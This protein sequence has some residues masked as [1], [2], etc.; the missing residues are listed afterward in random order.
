MRVLAL[1]GAI[2]LSAC[3]GSPAPVANVTPMAVQ[4]PSPTVST[5]PDPSPTPTAS[6]SP[7]PAPVPN[8]L[9]TITAAGKSLACRLPVTWDVQVDDHT[10][11]HKSGFIAF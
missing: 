11:L 2:L 4:S 8:P 10:A 3:A 6:P 5:S 9:I 7:S 1:V